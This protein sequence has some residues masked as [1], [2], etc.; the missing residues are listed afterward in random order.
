MKNKEIK[1]NFTADCCYK[2]FEKTGKISYYLL[3]KELT[4]K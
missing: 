3:F 2:M 4:E 1:E